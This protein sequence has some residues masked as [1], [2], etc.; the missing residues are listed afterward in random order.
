MRKPFIAGNWKM[1]LNRQQCIDLAKAIAEKH[2]SDGVE[3]ALCPPAI[4]LTEVAAACEGSK[5]GVGGRTCILKNPAHLR[6][7]SA[8]QC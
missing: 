4:Y 7:R 1:N 5:T 6:V 2:T 3:A 8:P